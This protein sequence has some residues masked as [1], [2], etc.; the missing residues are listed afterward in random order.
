M[1]YAHVVHAFP[2]STISEGSF[3]RARLRS[4][5]QVGVIGLTGMIQKDK[6]RRVDTADIVCVQEYHVHSNVDGLRVL[7]ADFLSPRRHHLVHPWPVRWQT[8]RFETNGY[9][10]HHRLR[11]YAGCLHTYIPQVM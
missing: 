3:C 9:R 1:R 2:F 10:T 8:I 7:S 6:P 5:N 4:S 11:A